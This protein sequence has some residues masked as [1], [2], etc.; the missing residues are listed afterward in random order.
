MSTCRASC[1]ERPG[2]NPKL[3][4]KKPASKTGL[5]TIFAAAC[6]TRSRTAGI[7]SGLSSLVPGL[8]MKTP[9]RQGRYRTASPAT[10]RQL[11]DSRDTPYSSASARLTRSMPAAPG[12]ARTSSTPWSSII[13][14]VDLCRQRMNRRPGPALPPGKGACCKALTLSPD[15]SRQGGPS[16]EYRRLTSQQLPA[17]A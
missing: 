13:P 11:T 1:A 6:T 10:P 8:R 16:R 15:D 17:R 12:W 2:R 4:G 7:D 3:H 9:G 14:A 5:D